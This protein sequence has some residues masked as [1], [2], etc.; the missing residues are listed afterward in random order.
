MSAAQAKSETIPVAQV[1]A[2]IRRVLLPRQILPHRLAGG[3][4]NGNAQLA[5]GLLLTHAGATVSPQAFAAVFRYAGDDPAGMTN[6]YILTLRRRLAP[7]G[8]T[9]GN[10]RGFGYQL[11]RDNADRLRALIAAERGQ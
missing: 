5:L 2:Y 11:D 7:H 10:V 1:D 3:P 9:I 4:L 8:I 6:Q